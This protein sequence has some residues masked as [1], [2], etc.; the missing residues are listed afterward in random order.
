MMVLLTK[1]EYDDLVKKAHCT[2]LLA[3]DK[4]NEM[5]QAFKAQL[6][7]QLNEAGCKHPS[8]VYQTIRELLEHY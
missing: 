8:E 6:R 7:T 3:E 1:R 5:K 4:F 2:G